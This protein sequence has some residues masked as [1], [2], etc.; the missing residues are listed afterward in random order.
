[1]GA[2]IAFRSSEQDDDLDMMME[3][4]MNHYPDNVIP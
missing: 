2:Q 1:M 4:N 3:V